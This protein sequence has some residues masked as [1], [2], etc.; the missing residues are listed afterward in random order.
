MKTTTATVIDRQSMETTPATVI[1]RQFLSPDYCSLI[2]NSFEVL[3][4]M[5]IDLES[6]MVKEFARG[7]PSDIDGSDV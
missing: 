4:D 2:K 3:D 7:L 1:D 5:E 6:I